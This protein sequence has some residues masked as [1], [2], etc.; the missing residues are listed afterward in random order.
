MLHV[1]QEPAIKLLE[2]KSSPSE[3]LAPHIVSQEQHVH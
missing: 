2:P 1:W 3:T